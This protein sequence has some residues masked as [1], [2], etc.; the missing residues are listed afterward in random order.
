MVE[1]H[2]RVV[3]SKR[4]RCATCGLFEQPRAR[5]P[6][7]HFLL[8]IARHSWCCCWSRVV[9]GAPIIMKRSEKLDHLELMLSIFGAVLFGLAGI[10][11]LWQVHSIVLCMPCAECVLGGCRGL[12][13]RAPRNLHSSKTHQSTWTWREPIHSTS[14]RGIH[15]T[16][17]ISWSAMPLGTRQTTA[18][19]QCLV[20]IPHSSLTHE[21]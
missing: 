5:S 19:C 20:D 9:S 21:W 15:T 2:L 17:N 11:F 4:H 6:P 18:M 12:Y 3:H 1:H 14:S 8:F 16:R 10:L 13:L 7:L